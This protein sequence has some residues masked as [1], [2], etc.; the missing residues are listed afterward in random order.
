M[1]R[2]LARALVLV[3]LGVCAQP[4]LAFD[5]IVM[6]LLS[7]AREVVGSAIARSQATPS[8]PVPVP[9]TKYPGTTVEPEQ[10]RRLIDECFVYLSDSQRREIFDSLNASLM[11]PKNA[12]VRGAMIEYFAARAVAVREAQ[13]RLSRL[14][15][16]DKERLLAEFRTA[17]AE[18]PAEEAAQLAALLRK[19]VL[20]VPGD[21]NAQ[22]LAAL[23][24]R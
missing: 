15:A 3:S 2:R 17:I 1:I 23:D 11:D 22:L 18:M 12:A 24:A 9:S 8:V 7:A 13:E 6:L 10:L 16:A 5:P 19:G 21:L 4:A 20:P 14:T